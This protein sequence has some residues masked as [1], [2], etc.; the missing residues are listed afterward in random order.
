MS[1]IKV[2]PEELINQIAAGEVVERPASIIKELIENSIDAGSQKIIVRIKGGGSELIEVEDDGIGMDEEDAK[3]SLIQH[4]TSKI[5]SVDD[6][7]KI[8]SLGFRGEALASISSVVGR[9]IIDTKTDSEKGIILEKEGNNL[10]VKESPKATKGTK[11]QIY[12]L[13]KNIPARKKFLKSENTERKH[14]YTSFI[15]EVL[16]F[17]NIHF[18]LYNEGK[19]IYRF[20]KTDEL[21]NRIF[22]VFGSDFVNNS[23]IYNAEINNINITGIIGNT[24]L[25]RKRSPI[26]Q[27]YINNRFVKS[28]LINSAVTKGYEGKMHRDLK[29]SFIILLEVNPESIDVNIHP[30]KLEIKFDDERMIF[31]S[32]YNFIS[33]NLEKGTRE[34]IKDFPVNESKVSK[35]SRVE[36]QSVITRNVT[37]PKAGMSFNKN[38]YRDYKINNRNVDNNSF[39]SSD[40]QKVNVD[41]FGNVSQYFNT[42]IVFEQNSELIFLDQHAAAEKILFEKLI[43]TLDD[44]RTKP[45]LIPEIINI[46][47]SEKEQI[48]NIKEDL[49]SLG[50]KID[51]FGDNSIQILEIPELS[52]INNFYWLIEDFLKDD[53]ELG[54]HFSDEIMTEYKLTKDQYL[55]L[56]TIA[57]HGSIRAGQVLSLEEMN[58][59]IKDTLSLETSYNC[60]HGRPIMWKLSKNKIE[61][62][63]NRDI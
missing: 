35:Q 60:P 3:M 20:T 51:D 38:L 23:E 59:I 15:N 16:P 26:Q 63:F 39:F 17:K 13:F 28:P 43:S 37:S 10:K 22:E 33:K 57:C 36:F 31:S 1:K 40:E 42:Y 46:D 5:K 56:A 55:R 24:Q 18:E 14:I 34:I 6:L 11:I 47:K 54:I 29:P 12:D 25:G 61:N 4:A 41:N 45:L 49:D 9:T 2:L 32:I 8:S 48:I 53:K 52:E 7:N 62:S 30:R 21:K 44:L 50:F 19:L 58:S 27:V